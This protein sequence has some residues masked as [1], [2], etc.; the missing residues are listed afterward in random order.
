MA[1]A[2][3]ELSEAERE[4]LDD[5]EALKLIRDCFEDLGSLDRA[6]LVS[7]EDLLRVRRGGDLLSLPELLLGTV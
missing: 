1:L 2:E 5:A 3:K 7:T 6:I 4:N